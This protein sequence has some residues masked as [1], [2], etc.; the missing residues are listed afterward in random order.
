MIAATNEQLWWFAARSSGVVLWVLMTSSVAWGLAVSAKLVRRKGLPA[1]MLDLHKHLAFLSIVFTAIHLVA[2]WADS[3]A[4]F[5]WAE[6][7]VPMASS[8]KPGPVAWGIVAMYLLVLV[9]VTSWLKRRIPR[10]V[11]HTI[12]LASLPMIVMGTIHGIT[13][14]TDWKSRTVQWGLIIG[15]TSIVWL[16]TFRALSPRAAKGS[17]RLAAARAAVAARPGGAGAAAAP[18]PPMPPS[19][20]APDTHR[21]GTRTAVDAT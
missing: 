21:S 10:Q 3:Y 6:L 13:A 1:W 11:W 17:E 18:M 2:L 16:A 14:G 15:A 19:W 9:Q 5:G 7:F 12:H 8:W 4:T 20:P